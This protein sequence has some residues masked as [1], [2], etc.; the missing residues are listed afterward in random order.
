M[1]IYQGTSRVQRIRQD[2]SHQTRIHSACHEGNQ[3]KGGGDEDDA[4][5]DELETHGQP[6]VDRDTWQVTNLIPVDPA[7]VRGD[8]DRLL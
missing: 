2:E 5:P 3:G 4:R 1:K 6:S 7:F 8:E